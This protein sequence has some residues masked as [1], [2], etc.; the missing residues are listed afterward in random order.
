MEKITIHKNKGEVFECQFKI[1]GTSIDGTEVRLCLEFDNNKNMFFYGTLENNGT[2]NIDIPI[3]KELANQNGKLFIEAIADSTY[4]RLYEADV[5]IKNSVEMAVVKK[6]TI[7]EPKKTIQ[8]EQ[9]TPRKKKEPVIEETVV[10]EE[11]VEESNNPYV[12][13]SKPKVEKPARKGLKKFGDF[14]K[15]K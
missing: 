10:E 12:V 15:N 9:I 14:L 7:K 1:D 5:E 2:C 11:T 13:G 3:L 4:F 6:P 8:L